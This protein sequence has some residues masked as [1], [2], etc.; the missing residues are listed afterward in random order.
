MSLALASPFRPN[1]TVNW[2]ESSLDHPFVRGLP[3]RRA[4]LRWNLNCW[5]AA[6]QN[7][8]RALVRALGV[9]VSARAICAACCPL[10][11]VGRPAQH[12]GPTIRPVSM[13]DAVKASVLSAN[14]S[15]QPTPGKWLA[16]HSAS[17]ARGRCARCLSLP[18]NLGRICAS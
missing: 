12:R 11:R 7:R 10:Y 15:R 18:I 5:L 4:G 17:L 16:V 3:R 1:Q 6:R 9:C 14:P 8:L 13:E 2:D